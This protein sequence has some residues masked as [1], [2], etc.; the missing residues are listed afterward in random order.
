[1]KKLLSIFASLLITFAA[2]ATDFVEGQHYV[3]FAD[4]ASEEPKV[5][6]FFSFYCGH[7]FAFEPL[8]KTLKAN[9]ELAGFKFEK[10]HVDFLPMAEKDQQFMLSKA[11][12]IAEELDRP[13]IID[14]IFK[15]I[16]VAKDVPENV[17]DVAMIFSK[18]GI[19]SDE[20]ND[21]FESFTVIQKAQ[22]MVEAQAYFNQAGVLKGVPTF[23]INEQYVVRPEGFK[24]IKTYDEFF[25]KVEELTT[26]LL[27]K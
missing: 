1:M 17:S 22:E 25:Q 18:A 27:R 16:H 12:V 21:L 20:F 2:S 3:K 26:F 11:L 5:T 23:I 8:A 14:E 4:K 7:C 19:S 24:G 15:Q 9:S 6:E 10:S 13:D